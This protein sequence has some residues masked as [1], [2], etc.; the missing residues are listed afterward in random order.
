M[1]D[2]TSGGSCS[3][4]VFSLAMHTNLPDTER[5][6]NSVEPKQPPCRML[7]CTDHHVSTR[8][9]AH[10]YTHTN[11]G[12]R[13]HKHT[14]ARSPIDERER[15]TDRQIDERERERERETDE[16]ERERERQTDAHR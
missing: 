14:G 11:R 15:E 6:M 4:I 5:S 12:T 2:T 7:L 9:R 13:I 1:A 8:T 16:R 10:T 3:T